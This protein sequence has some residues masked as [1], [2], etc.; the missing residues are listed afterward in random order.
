MLQEIAKRVTENS[1]T[2][3]QPDHRAV[4]P[5]L[6][7]DL[8][9]ELRA[10]VPPSGPEIIRNYQDAT[11]RNDGY[12]P[13]SFSATAI[14]VQDGARQTCNTPAEFTAPS[15]LPLGENTQELNRLP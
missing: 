14:S 3:W 11:D 7:R 12:L 8:M 1:G 13:A 9:T 2:V 6:P 15:A 4:I 5:A 10:I